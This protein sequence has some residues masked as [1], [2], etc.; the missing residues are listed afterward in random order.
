MA[1]PTSM[2]ESTKTHFFK[3]VSYF[4]LDVSVNA[5][6]IVSL[7]ILIRFYIISPFRVSGPSMCDT[8]NIIAGTCVSGNGEYI[9]V[10][11]FLYHHWFGTQIQP[12][13]R[14][15]IIVFRPPLSFK[16]DFYI[17]RIIGLPSETIQIKDGK[18]FIFNAENQSGF[19]LQETYLNE[20]NADKTQIGS[21]AQNSYTV[22]KNNYFVLGDNRNASSDSRHCFSQRG[23]TSEEATAF[24]PFENIEGKAWLVLWPLSNIRKI[25]S[26][27]W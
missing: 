1:F 26:E 27:I 18:V 9:I 11:K 7:V 22:P 19:E 25:P 14:G 2:Q 3:E 6:I 4:I 16:D 17:K 12:P 20:R 13:E 8:L 23:C 15:D 10:N 5:I 24:L 21:S